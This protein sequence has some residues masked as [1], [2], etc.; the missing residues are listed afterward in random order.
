MSLNLGFEEYKIKR[1]INHIGRLVKFC[2]L[3]KNKFGELDAEI[4]DGSLLEVGC[5]KVIYH[6]ENSNVQLVSVEA[7]QIK[8]KKIPMLLM[9]YDDFKKLKLKVN[10]IAIISGKYFLVSGCVNIQ[11]WNIA[12]DLSLEVL[13]IG[14][15]V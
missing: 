3:K 11:E 5:A 10:D 6:E 7:S 12:A 4:T 9:L 13:E 1:E 8:T 14:T 15:R 2:R